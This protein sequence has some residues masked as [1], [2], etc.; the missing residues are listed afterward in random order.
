[1]KPGGPHRR[2]PKTN[3]FRPDLTSADFPANSRGLSRSSG[4]HANKIFCSFLGRPSC[5]ASFMDPC[6]WAVL[7]KREQGERPMLPSLDPPSLAQPFQPNSQASHQPIPCHQLVNPTGLF[8][9]E[10][11]FA[12]YPKK[13]L[14]GKTTILQPPPPLIPRYFLSV[15]TARCCRIPSIQPAAK[16]PKGSIHG[17]FLAQM[18]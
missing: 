12:K 9:I 15:P 11:L 13:P 18:P 17:F 3:P 4:C 6:C 10:K 1:M 2:I 14:L 5:Q 7:F 8:A 16:H